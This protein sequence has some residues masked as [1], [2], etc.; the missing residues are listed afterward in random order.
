MGYAV[1]DT[2]RGPA[3]YGIPDVCHTAGCAE[4][5]D[6]GLGFLCGNQP[7]AADEY[8]CGWWFCAEHLYAPVP[9]AVASVV[10]QRDV[11]WL[12]ADCWDAF[13]DQVGADRVRR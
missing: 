13:A 7:G 2:P 1:Y 10:T 3:G 12:C 5:I 6:R 11:L 8:G 9:V 4:R